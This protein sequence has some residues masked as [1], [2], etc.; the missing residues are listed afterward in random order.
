MS[1]ILKLIK[2]LHPTGFAIA[3][4]LIFSSIVFYVDK[5]LSEE[6]MGT[7]MD[8]LSVNVQN[9][10]QDVLGSQL[11]SLLNDSLIQYR[12]VDTTYTINM[13]GVNSTDTTA[14]IPNLKV[15]YIRVRYCDAIV[16]QV[17]YDIDL[18][19]M[20]LGANNNSPFDKQQYVNTNGITV[21]PHYIITDYKNNDSAQFKKEIMQFMNDS[22]ETFHKYNKESG[23]KRSRLYFD[24]NDFGTDIQYIPVIMPSV[25][26]AVK[27]D[28]A[29]GR[30]T[31]AS[32]ISIICY[33]LFPLDYFMEG[34]LKHN[35]DVT[36][37]YDWNDEYIYGDK[38]TTNKLLN[39]IHGQSITV[40]AGRGNNFTVTF[41]P[42]EK[43][44]REWTFF[45]MVYI[46][47]LLISILFCFTLWFFLK[48][49][50]QREIALE[51][52]ITELKIVNDIK[53]KFFS[54]IAHDLRNPIVGMLNV[55]ALFNEYYNNM[56]LQEAEKSIN[57]L[58]KSI[59][60]LFKMLE[61]LLQWASV[62]TGDMKLN[63]LPQKIE[64]LV[65]LAF[66]DVDIMI[67]EEEIELIFENNTTTDVC[68]DAN[69]INSVLRNLISNAIK[70]SGGSNKV[71]VQ[72][73]NYFKDNRYVVI[74]VKDEGIGMNKDTLSK[75]FQLDAKF[76][77]RET[78]GMAGSRLGLILCKEFIDKHD[79]KIWVESE[80][81]K[82]SEFKFTLLKCVEDLTPVR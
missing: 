54:I 60:K 20:Y 1:K 63:I 34:L 61:N 13:L 28:S 29:T 4:M 49:I 19:K 12:F 38:V 32:Y 14:R 51:Q 64:Q 70:Y 37:K 2:I 78:L 27:I 71:T 40:T 26:T 43:F 36:V 41:A 21:Y 67:Q 80:I 74:T 48:Q 73:N 25:T 16:D 35:I 77:N 30:T 10:F 8:N 57:K 42:N 33:A 7:Q 52:S 50:K 68:C 76:Y 65:N 46:L 22:I 62:S 53:D 79:C 55:S 56:S 3:F 15:G 82:G 72:A 23:G 39:Q 47:L 66:D 59:T 5:K 81:G 17:K 45:P 75:L 18:S 9:Y 6:K 58:V 31:K 24:V 44:P 69:M 11:S